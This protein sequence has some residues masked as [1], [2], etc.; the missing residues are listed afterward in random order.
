M[1]T[2]GRR[3]KRG[4]RKREKEEVRL[5]TAH[6]PRPK[7]LWRWPAGARVGVRRPGQTHGCNSRSGMVEVGGSRV[8]S[9]KSDWVMYRDPVFQ[10]GSFS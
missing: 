1:R 4:G 7:M 9:S 6:D 2:E 10:K 8:L 3:K 5:E